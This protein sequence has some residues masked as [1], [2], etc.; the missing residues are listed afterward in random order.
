M[1]RISFTFTG[2]VDRARI[3]TAL[4]LSTMDDVDVSHMTSAE[5]IEEIKAG[6]LAI[7]FTDAISDNKSSDVEMDDY[8]EC[9]D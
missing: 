5:L 6:R 2:R 7:G 8:E 3:T 9:E 1:P 4:N